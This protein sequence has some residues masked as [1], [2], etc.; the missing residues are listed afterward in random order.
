[1]IFVDNQSSKSVHRLYNCTTDHYNTR[2]AS[3]P[4]AGWSGVEDLKSVRCHCLILFA[5]KND[6]L[7]LLNKQLSFMVEGNE[8]EGQ[9]CLNNQ[10]TYILESKVL[11]R[12]HKVIFFE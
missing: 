7:G 9:N 12:E 4:H 10:P 11:M 6:G 3:Q 8:K 5:G 1:M 2:E